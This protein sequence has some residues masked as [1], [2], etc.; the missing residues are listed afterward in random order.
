MKFD[1]EEGIVKFYASRYS[2]LS[3]IGINKLLFDV[4]IISTLMYLPKYL[5]T[6][7]PRY[8]KNFDCMLSG[9]SGLFS[10]AMDTVNIH[11]G[12]CKLSRRAF[13]IVKNAY[14]EP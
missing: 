3:L 10:C 13:F 2:I 5:P 8:M 6:Y 1:S 9:F 4:Y 14:P 12:A 7:T 11:F